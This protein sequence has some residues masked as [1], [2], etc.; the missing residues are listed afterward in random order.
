MQFVISYSFRNFDFLFGAGGY[1]IRELT[2]TIQF[3]APRMRIFCGS[4]SQKSCPK[5][6]FRSDFVKLG[7]EI[8]IFLAEKWSF[9]RSK[10]IIHVLHSQIGYADTY[11]PPLI[12]QVLVV[13]SRT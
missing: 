2:F 12:P 10:H 11:S 1:Y 6:T 8:L 5:R 13:G 9:V 3:M 7:S 4:F